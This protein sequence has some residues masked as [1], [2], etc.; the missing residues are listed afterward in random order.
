MDVL[1]CRGSMP[2]A[3]RQR[4]RPSGGNSFRTGRK[5]G[6]RQDL[7]LAASYCS[8]TLAGIRPRSL[9]AMPWSFAQARISPLR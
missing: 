7:L 4:Q 6:V 1:S 5:P 8:T 9:T 2:L 3:G